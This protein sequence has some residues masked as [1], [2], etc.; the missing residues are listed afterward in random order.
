M[1][2][3]VSRNGAVGAPSPE[4]GWVLPVAHPRRAGLDPRVEPGPVGQRAAAATAAPKAA[5]P[6]ALGCS[7]AAGLVGIRPSR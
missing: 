5:M 3:A 1:S 6:A 4:R 7:G 2:G